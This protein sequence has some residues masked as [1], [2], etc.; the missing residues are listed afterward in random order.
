MALFGSKKNTDT[1]VKAPK[2]A[3]KKAVK[4]TAAPK[5]KKEKVVE[6]QA[7]AVVSPKVSTHPVNYS[8]VLSRPRITEKAARLAEVSNAYTFEIAKTASKHDVMKAVQDV[9]HVAARKVTITTLP[10]KTKMIRGKMG[11]RAGV[12]KAT[13]FLKK[14]D[15]IE[16]V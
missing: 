10:G 5:V 13:V 7:A 16:F 8:H 3:V 12:K 11:T 2:V 14:G 9:Y 6:T 15:K 1:E 4:R